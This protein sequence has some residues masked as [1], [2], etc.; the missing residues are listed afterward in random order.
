M[1]Q[2]I[3]H[4]VIFFLYQFWKH[5][6]LWAHCSRLFKKGTFSVQIFRLILCV[7]NLRFRAVGCVRPHVIIF[8]TLCLC[9]FLFS[10]FLLNKIKTLRVFAI[11][12]SYVMQSG[13]S[14]VLYAMEILCKFYGLIRNAMEILCKFYGL[15][16]KLNHSK[17]I[18]SL[19]LQFFLLLYCRLQTCLKPLTVVM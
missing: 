14:S 16:R 4:E 18:A 17:N 7:M 12:L 1:L 10:S 2:N 15:I 13:H 5:I 8:A 9:S 6:A 3:I 11:C 19:S